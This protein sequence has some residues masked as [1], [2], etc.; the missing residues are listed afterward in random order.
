M[1][2]RDIQSTH[3]KYFRYTTG[4][5]I[6]KESHR[7]NKRWQPCHDPLHILGTNTTGAARVKNKP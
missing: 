3:I 1:K 6:H 4:L 7:G 5:F 2:L